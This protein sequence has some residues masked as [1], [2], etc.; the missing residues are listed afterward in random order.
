[1]AKFIHFRRISVEFSFKSSQHY[2]RC[3]FCTSY[4]VQ[5]SVLVNKGIKD[6]IA[7]QHIFQIGL[8]D[9][10]SVEIKIKIH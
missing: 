2:I 9:H 10:C 1:M 6:R 3:A 7:E 8:Q 5:S 4:S